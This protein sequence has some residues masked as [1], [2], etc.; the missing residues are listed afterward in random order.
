M[1][2]KRFD[3]KTKIA[4]LQ[5][6]ILSPDEIYPYF[7]SPGNTTKAGLRVSGCLFCAFCWLPSLNVIPEVDDEF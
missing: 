4:D 3:W 1:N 7:P 2:G 5:F 6:K